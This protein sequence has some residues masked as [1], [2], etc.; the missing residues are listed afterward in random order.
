MIENKEGYIFT[1][2]YNQLQRLIKERYPYKSMEIESE[3]SMQSISINY[4]NN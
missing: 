2:I 4:F 1:S 3:H